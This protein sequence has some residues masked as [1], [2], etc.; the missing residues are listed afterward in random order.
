[1]T[2]TLELLAAAAVVTSPRSA[3]PS[4][5]KF[6]TVSVE[7]ARS[8]IKIKN[9]DKK[10]AEDGSQNLTV[11]IG[12]HTLPLSNI[13]PG[14]TRIAVTAEQVE[15]YSEALV[16]AVNEGLFDDFIVI[17]QEKATIQAEKAALN[18]VK[19]S[20]KSVPVAPEAVEGLD[21]DELDS[22]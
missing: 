5:P 7:E 11:T 6:H 13:A 9:G 18:P 12:K 17:A 22:L 21:L 16:A 4:A 19:R 14:A 2:I 1:M 20:P 8:F 3:K 15:S 10:P